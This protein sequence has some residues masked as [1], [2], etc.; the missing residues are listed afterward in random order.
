MLTSPS[1]FTRC[2][3]AK[4]IGFAL[5]LLG[6][7]VL[8]MMQADIAPKM[9]WAMLLWYTTFGGIIGVIGVFT[10][11]PML[12]INLPWWL[13]SGVIGAWLNFVLTLFI[14]D[15]LVVL[16]G[17]LFGEQGWFTSP[18]WFA[19]EGLMVGVFI[20]FFAKKYG[21]IGPETAGR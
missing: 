1:L 16:M 10:Y 4:S 20:G 14:Y 6:F 13:T 15:D 11:H 12:K 9:Q 7:F 21:G 18:Y 8:P 19:L 17:A 5:G 3:V 2:V